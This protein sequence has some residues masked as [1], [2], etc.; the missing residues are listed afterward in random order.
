M[1]NPLTQVANVI[2][3]RYPKDRAQSAIEHALGTNDLSR[4][5]FDYLAHL[6][7]Q[8]SSREP[9]CKENLLAEY[10]NS[11]ARTLTH[12]LMDGLVKIV[13]GINSLDLVEQ[14]PDSPRIAD[15]ERDANQSI[16]MAAHVMAL[17]DHN[18]REIFGHDD[19]DL[20]QLL[21]AIREDVLAPVQEYVSSKGL[22][23][24]TTAEHTGFDFFVEPIDQKKWA[25]LTNVSRYS[26]PEYN[27]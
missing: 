7:S 9:I 8:K 1:T 16:A 4:G 19:T 18:F 10:G 20:N 25:E 26:P 22:E 2:R 17:N 3:D 13:D 6:D 23:I 12:Y 15:V 21:D 14:Y 5:Q 11:P 24:D 27:I